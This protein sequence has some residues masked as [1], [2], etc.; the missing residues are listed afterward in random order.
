M[1]IKRKRERKY[2]RLRDRLAAALSM[3]LPQEQRDE[4]R[5][6]K[7]T[8]K[9]VIGLFDQD[10]VVLHSLGGSDKWWN[11][12]PMLR[13]PHRLKSQQDTSTVAKVRRLE[14]DAVDF[15][16]RVLAKPCGAKR[17]KSGKWH[18]RP[19]PRRK[20]RANNMSVDKIT[21]ATP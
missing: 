20:V 3:L 2:L 4:L 6:R 19:W 1:S 5:S 10:H 21:G 13:H 16:R 15:R 11:L 18:N 17:P 14:Q 8:A 7:A 9:E 12:T